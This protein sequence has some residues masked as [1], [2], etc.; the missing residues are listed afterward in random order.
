M[1]DAH[2]INEW[3][4]SRRQSITFLPLNA[5][6]LLALCLFLWLLSWWWPVPAWLAA[7][8]VGALAFVVVGDALNIVLLGRK[9]RGAEPVSGTESKPPA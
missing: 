9:L 6:A 4:K 3:R 1:A 8:L 5:A 7:I 2:Q